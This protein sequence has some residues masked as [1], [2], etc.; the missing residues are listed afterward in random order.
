MDAT[1]PPASGQAADVLGS[2]AISKPSPQKTDKSDTS[3]TSD[4][5]KSGSS[6]D[7][8]DDTLYRLKTKDALAAGAMGRDE[9]ELT[10]KPRRRERV[11][12]VE[13]TK[14]LKSSGTDPK[15]Q[16][17]LL[18]SSVTS[19]EDVGEKASNGTESRETE[20]EDE[21]DARFK[22]KRLVFSQQTAD[23]SKEKKKQTHTKAES[24]PSP[25]PSATASVSKR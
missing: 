4:S 8:Q 19:I 25:S 14:Q 13:S 21:S 10:R 18:H 22:A 2:A 5:D 7:V 24:S 17:S 20:P 1:P 3:D 9:G 15:F 12:E 23:A 11:S 16:G 6:D